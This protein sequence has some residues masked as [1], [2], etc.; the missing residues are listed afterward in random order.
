MG[1]VR[2]QGMFVRN[3]PHPYKIEMSKPV[4]KKDLESFNISTL[5][6]LPYLVHL[7]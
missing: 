3:V 2:D 1:G 4:F 7:V 6:Q 5:V